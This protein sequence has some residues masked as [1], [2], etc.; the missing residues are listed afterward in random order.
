MVSLALPI[1]V[2]FILLM[3]SVNGAQFLKTTSKSSFL[4]YPSTSTIVIFPLISM[5]ASL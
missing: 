2:L 5:Y 3:Q 1:Y 4:P